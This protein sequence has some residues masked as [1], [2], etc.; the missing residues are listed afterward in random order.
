MSNE[1]S[2]PHVVE[3]ND[4]ERL[5]ELRLIWTLLA[6]QTRGASF[7]HTLDWLQCYW[8]H[9]GAGQHLRV[10]VVLSGNKPIGIL[11]L[12]VVRERTRVG[13]V[14]VLTY[15]LH[16]WGTFFGPIGPNPT[17][18][19]T[20]AMQ[21]IRN[22][23]R[24]WE[25]LDMRWVNRH[26]HD[27]LRTQWAIEHAGYSALETTWKT[28]TLIDMQEGWEPYWQSRSS[29]LRNNVSRDF[30][31]VEQCGQVEHV[32]YRPAGAV[33][34][35]DDPRWDLY[36]VCVELAEAS[37]QG[38]SETGTTLSHPRVAVFLREAHA[39][40]ARNGMVDINLLFID[41]KPVAFSYNYV[42]NGRLTGIRRG[43]L[44]EFADCGVGNVLFVK[45]LRDSFDRDDQ[46]LDLG[47]ESLRAK[48][49]W[50]T[51]VI[52]SYRYTHYPLLAPRAQLLRLKHRVTAGPANDKQ[53]PAMAR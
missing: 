31:H 1:P 17:A 36:D 15:P 49:R 3:I 12:T 52:N 39:L 51:R 38:S 53:G 42:T 41:G 18:T 29:K 20:L 2:R 21:H 27:H 7:F 26:E 11:P 37:W 28:T 34:G 47:P 16:D 13:M 32:R 43:H 45:M 40:A 48:R 5:E 4:P 30:R 9:F 8:K 10:L 33:Y 44:P 6:S 35:D 46:C 50:G 22:T 24:D 14:R 23:P 19:L 25:L